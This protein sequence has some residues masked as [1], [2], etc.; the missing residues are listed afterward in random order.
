MDNDVVRLIGNPEENFYTLGLR[1]KIGHEELSSQV[2]TMASGRLNVSKFLSKGIEISSAMLRNDRF[3]YSSYLKAYAEGLG[4]PLRDVYALLLIPE[5]I[6]SFHKWIPS[7]MGIIPGCSSLFT[8]DASNHITHSRIL[9]YPLAEYYD[10][11]EQTVLYHLSEQNKVFSF[12]TQGLPFPSLTSMNEYGLTMALHYKHG[13]V[14]NLKGQSIF[15]LA[16]KVISM[17]RDLDDVKKILR[18]EKSVSSWGLYFSNSKDTVLAVDLLGEEQIF[19]KYDFQ[20]SPYLYFN[21]L[22]LKDGVKE[23]VSPYGHQYQCQMRFNSI[24]QKLGRKKTFESLEALTK[25]SAAPQSNS[26]WSFDALTP[27]S[28][29]AVAFNYQSDTCLRVKGEAPKFSSNEIEKIMHPFGEYSCE[30]IK[31]ADNDK[32]AYEQGMRALALFQSTFDRGEVGLSYHYIQMAIEHFKGHKWQDISRFYFMVLQY[33]YEK[34]SRDLSYLYEDLVSLEG[35]LPKYL[36]DHRVLFLMRLEKILGHTILKTTK[37]IQ[38]KNIQRIYEKERKLRPA[39]IK[40][41]RPLIFPRIDILDIIYG[42]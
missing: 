4:V 28:M 32:T 25:L 22:L 3:L 6:A 29:A 14:L 11:Y 17:A 19:K 24:K 41:M 34:D 36:D 35:K 1:D 18:S 38:N 26:K 21:N 39:I 7:F 15:S 12:Q 27:G 5:F 10:K 33:L 31:A 20:N 13:N 37:D 8:K 16:Y 23:D 40:M 9:D 30:V 42:H 2:K